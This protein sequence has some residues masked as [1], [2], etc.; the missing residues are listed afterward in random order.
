MPCDDAV[1]LPTNGSKAHALIDGPQGM[2][3]GLRP[4]AI[5]GATG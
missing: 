1:H 2:M 4:P 5:L 3:T